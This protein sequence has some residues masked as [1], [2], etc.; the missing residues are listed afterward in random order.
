MHHLLEWFHVKRTTIKR[1]VMIGLEDVLPLDRKSGGQAFLDLIQW[2]DIASVNSTL[3]S[4]EYHHN[5][6]LAMVDSYR[7]LSLCVEG[8]LEESVKKQVI[9]RLPVV[10]LYVLM[11]EKEASCKFK[12]PTLDQIKEQMTLK[13]ISVHNVVVVPMTVEGLVGLDQTTSYGEEWTLFLITTTYLKTLSRNE[14]NHLLLETHNLTIITPRG[15]KYNSGN[16]L[17]RKTISK[18]IYPNIRYTLPYMKRI[19][20]S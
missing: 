3:F 8:C 13:F 2:S 15:K 20:S 19:I 6:M 17:F 16:G 14:I 12:K 11:S 1:V 5:Q 9:P 18:Q 10:K 7:G 4:H